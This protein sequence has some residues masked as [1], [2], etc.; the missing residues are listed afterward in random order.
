MTTFCV[1]A[2]QAKPFATKAAFAGDAEILI[3][4]G[5]LADPA[6]ARQDALSADFIDWQGHDGQ[7]YKRVCLKP[8][9]GL[10]EAI[11]RVYGPV[12][13]FGQGYRLN[14][15]GE[16][17]NQ[18][19]HSDLGWGTHAAVVYLCEGPGGTAFWRHKA[20]G[21][22]RIQPGDH[23]LFEA[24]GSDWESE[25]AWQ[26]VGTAELAFNRGVL[27]DNALFH[28]RH[29]FEAFGADAHNGRLIAVAFFTPEAC[30]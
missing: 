7:I 14:F 30:K 1:A 4:D 12:E 23:E 8:V 5:F 24:I 19:I 27:Y 10:V 25:Q 21:A 9:P 29:P 2:D 16:M 11:E 6:A 13:V 15:A 17:P 22:D 26:M 18:S 28:S 3:S 20:T